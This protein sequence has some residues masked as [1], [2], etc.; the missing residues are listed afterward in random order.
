MHILLLPSWYPANKNDIRGIYFRDQAQALSSNGFK[1]GVISVNMRSLRTA[2][3]ITGSQNP[4]CSMEDDDGV[5]IYR[6]RIWAAFPRIPYGNYLLWKRSSD[7]LLKKYVAHNGWPD[8]V[9]AHSS[10]FAGVVAAH[11]KKKFGL[12]YVLTEHSSSFPRDLL[13]PWHIKLAKFAAQNA[14]VRIAVS[15]ALRESLILKLGSGNGDWKWIPNIVGKR[16]TIP[17]ENGRVQKES[18]VLLSLAM[19]DDNKGHPDLLQAYAKAFQGKPDIELWFAGDGPPMRRLQ[20][21]AKALGISRSVKFLGIVPPEDVPD[22]LRHADVMIVTSYYET[23]CVAAAEA[24]IMGVPVLSTRCGGPECI[25]QEGDGLLV[26]PGAPDEL[27]Q[28]LQR[29]LAS[30]PSMNR[31]D[32]TARAYRR[33]SAEAVVPQLS[34]IYDCVLSHNK[35]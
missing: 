32:I 13:K 21:Q 14:D 8:L 25:V 27:S 22:L 1:V 7:E 24:L 12:P 9:H 18:T 16:F 11:W 23:F 4:A 34:E 35:P 33:F 20:N 29:M 31:Q 28:A 10:L 2:F 26:P 30:L 15:P 17:G 6:H 3:R 5:K 19:M